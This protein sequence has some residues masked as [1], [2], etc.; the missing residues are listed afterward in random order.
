MAQTQINGGTQIRTGS[1]TS[2][3]L[4]AGTVA[5]DRLVEQYAKADGSRAFSGDVSLG[6][7]LLTNVADPVNG[8]DAANKQY[9]D[10][11]L[12][13]F[14]WKQSVRVG[15]S[16]PGTLSSS[17]ANGSVVDGVTLVTGDRVLV[18]DQANGSENGIYTVNAS[19]APSRSADANAS[20]EV[21]AGVTVFISE[22]STLGNSAWSLTSDDPVD[23]GTTAL[24]FTQ[25]AGGSLYN[26]GSGLSLNGSSFDVVAAD[27][28]LTVN[29]DNVQVRVGDG[30]LEVS[31]GLR[32]KQGSAGQV[33]IANGS[34]VL[35]PTDLSGDVYGVSG[36]GSVTLADHI[37]RAANYVVRETPSG[38]VNDA[39]TSFSLANTP[40]NG[41]DQVYLNGILQDPGVGNDYTISGAALNFQSAPSS[42]DK[43]RVTYLKG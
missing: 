29:S 4:A 32:V 14:D 16:G 10:G 17:F 11:L 43:I 26:A 19:G 23:L 3:R 20:A 41:T 42:G 39:N 6:D 37:V 24:V 22:G 40:V 30:S 9:V 13:G 1:I 28:S 7:N 36:S 25:V 2:D 15:S 8:T 12:Q 31:N 35:T 18:K 27:T 21:T 5:D 38:S 33:Y 34:G